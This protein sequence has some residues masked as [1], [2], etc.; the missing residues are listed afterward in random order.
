MIS[1]F[2]THPL[3]SSSSLTFIELN[4][5]GGSGNVTLNVAGTIAQTGG[6]VVA[7]QLNVIVGGGISLATRVN[8]LDLRTTAVGDVSLTDANGAGLQLGDVQVLKRF[9]VCHCH[10]LGR[11]RECS[12]AE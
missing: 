5:G 12:L 2:T 1:F 7:D 9:L 6:P 10:R 11:R 3:A 4:A 8:T